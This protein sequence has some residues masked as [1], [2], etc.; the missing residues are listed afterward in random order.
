[1]RVF[2]DRLTLVLCG[3]VTVTLGLGVLGAPALAQSQAPVRV[4]GTATNGAP[5]ALTVV[6]GRVLPTRPFK[7]VSGV[8][9]ATTLTALGGDCATPGAGLSL[10]ITD[11]SFDASAA[12]IAADAFPTLKSGTGGT[13]GAAT[14]VVWTKVTAAAVMAV[15]TF[16]TPLKLTAAHELCWISSTAGSKAVV[17]SGFIAP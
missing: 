10:Y 9:T 7:C 4:F 8:L 11:L 1:M 5:A 2:V 12:G 15:Q 6:G 16:A 14:A 17:I 3:I 13:C